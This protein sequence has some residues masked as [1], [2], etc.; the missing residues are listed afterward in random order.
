MTDDH[1]GDDMAGDDCTGDC[2]EALHELYV[3]IDGELTDDRRE[4]IRHHLD[5]CNPCLEA[6]DFEAE[7]RTVIAQ[8]CREEVPEALRER[9][10]D[11]LRSSEQAG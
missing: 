7:L 4:R 6:F 5:D 1:T 2:N 3:F 10:A 11:A 8:R 9:I